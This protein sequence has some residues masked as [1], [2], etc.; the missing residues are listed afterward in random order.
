MIQTILRREFQVQCDGCGHSAP[1]QA[2][3]EKA[4]EWVHAEGWK[5]ITAHCG[6]ALLTTW[7]CP[8]C[9]HQREAV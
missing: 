3:T 1:A 9:Q 4:L 7:L 8:A 5:P 6:F 2:T